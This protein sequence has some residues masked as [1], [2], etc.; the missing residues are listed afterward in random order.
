MPGIELSEY[1][2]AAKNRPDEISDIIDSVERYNPEKIP[3]LEAYLDAQLKEDSYDRDANLALLKLYQ[4]NPDL[5]NVDVIGAV[6]VK[7]LT[8]MPDPD[9][10]LACCLLSEDICAQT[11]ITTLTKL[12]ELLETASF[13]DFWAMLR[14]NEEARRLVDVCSNFDDRVRDFIARIVAIT[15][16]AVDVAL[17]SEWLDL[18]EAAVTE[19]C[20][21]LGWTVED[22]AEGK[23]L[24]PP[25]SRDN[26][27]KPTVVTE[28]LKF[29]SLTKLIAASNAI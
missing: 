28:S 7:T 24:S 27:I 15:Y 16:Q 1:L 18:D 20:K 3:A 19:Y 25:L 4:F 29:E 9:F 26:D 11:P 8:A 5:H 22:G 6:L 10:N 12:Q 21:G 23:V 2:S 13:K 14:E 17:V